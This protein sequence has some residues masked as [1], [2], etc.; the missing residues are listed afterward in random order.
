LAAKAE[1]KANGSS[2]PA[3]PN[4]LKPGDSNIAIGGGKISL[5]PTAFRKLVEKRKAALENKTTNNNIR[6]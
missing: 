2:V 3:P 1:K 5:N 6:G 4:I